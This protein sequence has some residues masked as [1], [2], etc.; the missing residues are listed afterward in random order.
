[1]LA[2]DPHIVARYLTNDDAEQ[3]IRAKT[4]VDAADVLVSLTVMLEAEWVL[5][6]IYRLSRSSVSQ[7]CD[8]SLACLM[9]E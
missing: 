4:L 5:R 2:L 7:A 1:M 8:H 3:S 6:S 9:S